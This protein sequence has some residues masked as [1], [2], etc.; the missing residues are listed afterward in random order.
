GKA[1]AGGRHG[2]VAGQR[3][4]DERVRDEEAVA[5]ALEG[6]GGVAPALL[7]VEQVDV[8][9]EERAAM[10]RLRL[11]DPQ[12][13]LVLAQREPRL[14]GLAFHD[15][16]TYHDDAWRSFGMIPCDSM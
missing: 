6:E 2:G 1:P 14:L 15:G 4:A 16:R 10:D 3:D 12:V 8:A 13:N 5:I 7:V 9:L 11:D